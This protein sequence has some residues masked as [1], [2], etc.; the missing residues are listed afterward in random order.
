M[1]QQLLLQKENL[2]KHLE[3]FISRETEI[4]QCKI[5]TL[6]K[7]QTGNNLQVKKLMKRYGI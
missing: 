3:D 7:D 6:I 4:F 2:K 5:T 1:V